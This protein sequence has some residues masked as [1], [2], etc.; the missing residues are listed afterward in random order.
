LFEA[1]ENQTQGMVHDNRQNQE[2]NYTQKCKCAK[3]TRTI[4]KMRIQQ[5]KQS[6][7]TS[8][9]YE[10]LSNFKE[11]ESKMAVYNQIYLK[12]KKKQKEER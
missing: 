12:K 7:I 11:P 2:Y 10:A 8:N 1:L 5:D 4:R 3:H 9:R 6:I